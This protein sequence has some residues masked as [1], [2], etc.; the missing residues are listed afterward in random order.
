[1]IGE[2]ERIHR[3]HYRTHD[4]GKPVCGTRSKRYRITGVELA[5]TCE[6]CRRVIERR[7]RDGRTNLFGEAA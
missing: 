6:N 5:V 7:K 3:L 4:G 2:Y 1:M